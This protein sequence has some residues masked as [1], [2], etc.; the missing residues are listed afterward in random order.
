MSIETLKPG[1]WLKLGE[2]AHALGVSEITL[3]RKV[4]CGKIPHDFRNGKYFVYLYKD[5]KTG[6]YYDPS[7]NADTASYLAPYENFQRLNQLPSINVTSGV[8]LAHIRNETTLAELETRLQESE[9]ETF[10]LQHSL[11]L[12]DATLQSLRRTL[13]DQQTLIAFL[14]ETIKHLGNA[15]DEKYAHAASAAAKSSAPSTVQTGAQTGML[16]THR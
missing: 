14:E 6:K 13:E 2:A 5:E 7:G 3:R 1:S 10:S 11:E 4:K 15:Q 12:K 8:P 9:D 16:R